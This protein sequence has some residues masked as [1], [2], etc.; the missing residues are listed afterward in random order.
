[1]GEVAKAVILPSFGT[2]IIRSEDLDDS[3][4]QVIDQPHRLFALQ[5]LSAACHNVRK[6]RRPPKKQ[7]VTIRG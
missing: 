3:A 4:L 6:T 1:M 2:L 7:S 5:L